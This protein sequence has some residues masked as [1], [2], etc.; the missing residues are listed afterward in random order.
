[1]QEPIAIGYKSKRDLAGLNPIL[2]PMKQQY[3]VLLTVHLSMAD[4]L[5]HVK[6]DLYIL[7]K[8]SKHLILVKGHRNLWQYGVS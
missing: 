5:T 7:S 6:Q 2:V 8:R 3:T 4:L 1:M